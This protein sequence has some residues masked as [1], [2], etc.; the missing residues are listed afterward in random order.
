MRAQRFR[1][2]VPNPPAPSVRLRNQ[3]GDLERDLVNGGRSSV[4]RSKTGALGAVEQ[5]E[6]LSVT[7]VAVRNLEECGV[8]KSSHKGQTDDLLVKP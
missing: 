5:G 3:Q 7:S 2:G 1:L 6:R 8:R 4:R